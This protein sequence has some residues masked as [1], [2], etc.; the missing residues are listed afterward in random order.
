MKIDIHEEANNMSKILESMQF[1]RD[2]DVYVGIQQKD[3]SR[4]DDDDTNAELLFIH[5]NGSPE[6]NIPPRPVIDPAIRRD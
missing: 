4:E 5:T 6:N 3:T 2:H 1:I